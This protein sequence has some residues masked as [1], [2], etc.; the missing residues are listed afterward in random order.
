MV[1]DI[2]GNSTIE[3]LLTKVHTPLTFRPYDAVPWF[4][5]SL[6]WVF[7]NTYQPVIYGVVHSYTDHQPVFEETT[8]CTQE[9]IIFRV[10]PKRN[11]TVVMGESERP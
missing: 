5:I 3:K 11:G 1:S 7:S 9:M 2:A 8:P 4:R 6:Q 10:F